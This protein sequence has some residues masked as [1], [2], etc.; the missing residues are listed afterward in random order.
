MFTAAPARL[1]HSRW[2]PWA[3]LALSVAARVV[4][5]LLGPEPFN[6][7]DLK[8][9]VEGAQ[10]LTD[11]TL[12]DFLSGASKLPF[13]YPPFSALLFTPLSWLPWTLTRILWQLGILA[14]LPAIIYLTLRL[15]GRA[16]RSAVRPL[17]SLR[18]VL[19]TGA[20]LAF[21]LEPVGTTV[22]YGQI[23]L[24]LALLILGGAVAAKDWLAGAGVGLAAGIKL[25]PAI[26][27]LYYLLQ[28]RF[29]VLVWSVLVF[30]GTV[31]VMFVFIGSETTRFFTTLIF[32]PSRT[33]PVFSAINQSWRGVLYRF[34]GHDVTGLWLAAC[35]VTVGLGGW[36]ALAAARAGDR[37]GSL[38][39]VQFTGLLV[40]PI[41]WSHHWVWV[42]P[43]LVWGLFGPARAHRA[44]RG[45][46]IAWSVAA[47]S[48]LIPILV[49]VQGSPP[50]VARP[51]WQ[52]WAAS[53]YVVLGML[54]LLVIALVS[55][56]VA[57]ARPEISYTFNLTRES[58]APG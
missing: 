29:A 56:V 42:L 39:A 21:W 49:A 5:T 57:A 40:S 12:Y 51:A 53:A 7:I 13:T 18:G 28:R 2:A 46:V 16:G 15:L 10:H 22:N 3:L 48:Y 11:G 4:A 14:S 47:Y 37:A 44:V 55:R 38:L 36:A 8:V 1:V 25:I 33:G 58:G 30:A 34:A 31:A 26:T 19:I 27:G 41:S 6:M 20:A 32:D 17:E 43:L 54:T 52:T 24:F 35:V 45:V 50:V 9:Y 23:N